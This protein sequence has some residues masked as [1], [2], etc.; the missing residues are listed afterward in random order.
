MFLLQAKQYRQI[1]IK[2]KRTFTKVSKFLLVSCTSLLMIVCRQ[3]QSKGLFDR[4]SNDFLQ[5]WTLQMSQWKPSQKN[6]LPFLVFIYNILL[7]FWYTICF[8]F[9]R[10]KSLFRMKQIRMTLKWV[11]TVNFV[12]SPRKLKKKENSENKNKNHKNNNQQTVKERRVWPT[13]NWIRHSIRKHHQRMNQAKLCYVFPIYVFVCCLFPW[14][15]RWVLMSTKLLAKRWK[16]HG[17]KEKQ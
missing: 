2:T 13:F 1:L 16:F 17:M 7:L 11:R 4:Y 12:I 9:H 8:T 3:A 6:H 14:S 10:F 15:F 5:R